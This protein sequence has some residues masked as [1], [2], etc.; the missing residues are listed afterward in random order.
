MKI[1]VWIRPNKNGEPTEKVDYK[2]ESR[3]TPR[4]QNFGFRLI[5][6]M[7]G[8]DIEAIQKKRKGGE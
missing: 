2:L 5:K 1:T 7:T 4:I 8:E 6:A 3:D